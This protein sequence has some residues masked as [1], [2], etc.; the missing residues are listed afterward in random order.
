ML[1]AAMTTADRLARRILIGALHH[2]SPS[3]SCSPKRPFAS[4]TR[5][6]RISERCDDDWQA[7]GGG[8]ERLFSFGMVGRILSNWAETVI[9]PL[10]EIAAAPIASSPR[11]L[12]YRG[13]EEGTLV[14]STGEARLLTMRPWCFVILWGWATRKS[15][16]D[17]RSLNG[18]CHRLATAVCVANAR[19]PENGI[20]SR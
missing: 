5:D 9:R 18:A 20:A 8:V 2:L 19:L 3:A 10:S 16:A 12:S 15:S 17:T 11:R 13:I 14:D 4:A 6:R 7:L 1:D